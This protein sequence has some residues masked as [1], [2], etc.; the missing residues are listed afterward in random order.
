MR[1]SYLF[2]LS[3]MLL[4]GGAVAP[5]L[6]QE[7]PS[8]GQRPEQG[9]GPPIRVFVEE[10]TIPFIVTDNRNRLIT[11]LAKDDF[12][13]LE[14]KQSQEITSFA[15]ET[16]VPLRIGLLVDTSNSIRDRLDFEQ[17]AGAEFLRNVLR[18]GMDKALLGSFDSMA[19]LLQDFTDDLD[20]L[21]GAIQ[22]MRAGGGTALYDAVYY[23]S[24]DRL[25]VEAPLESGFR[26]ALVVLSDGEDN[27]SRFSRLQTL[28]I[29]RRAEVTIY[30]I[31]TNI[32]GIRT[33]GDKVLEEFSEETG[34][35]FF[36]PFS[37]DD[38]DEAFNAIN[39]E[40]RSQYTVSFRPTT[41]RDG[42]FHEIQI[43]PKQKGLR[44]RAR[45]GYFATEPL[46]ALPSNLPPARSE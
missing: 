5:A 26:R 34:G 28:E 22:M 45:R 43:V 8:P 21:I 2:L 16:G 31:S 30:T 6:A 19:E 10:V 12:E 41:P 44:V 17:R 38:L 7:T 3:L 18:P 32:R 37:W 24:R 35:R 46:G 15:R 42:Q 33:P 27:Q 25:M 13:V 11:D 9:E 36:R 29:A 4:G 39:A 14:E 20:Q 23:A 40:L 1:R